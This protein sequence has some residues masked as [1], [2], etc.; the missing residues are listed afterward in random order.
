MDI[1]HTLEPNSDQLDAVELLGGPR[2]FRIEKVTAGNAEQPV[3]IHLAG[4]PRPWR[5]GKSMRRILAGCWG[6][7]AS[8]YVGR[9]VEL[10]CDPDVQ[11]GGKSVGGTRISRLSHIDAAKKIPLLVTRGKSATFTVQPID[12]KEAH[13]AALRGEW[14]AADAD[15][16]KAI[17]AEVAALQDGAA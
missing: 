7:D 14:K 1:A 13:V 11:F 6:T 8:T 4:F 17:E 2:V 16:K 15:R 12:E 9:Y 10:Y 3:N 5:P